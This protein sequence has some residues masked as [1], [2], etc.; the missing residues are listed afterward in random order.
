MEDLRRRRVDE[1]AVPLHVAVHPRVVGE[2]AQ[3]VLDDERRV[4]DL[5]H[6][7][8]GEYLYTRARDD[9]DP[10]ALT[11]Q[12]R[13]REAAVGEEAVDD[14]LER[15]NVGRVLDAVGEVAVEVAR[16]P[17]PE[18]RLQGGLDAA[19]GE[20]EVARLRGARCRRARDD[21]RGEL[22]GDRLGRRLLLHQRHRDLGVQHGDGGPVAL[23]A[24]PDGEAAGPPLRDEGGRLV[25]D[26]EVG[27]QLHRHV[28]ELEAEPEVVV[29]PARAQA[30]LA[31][32]VQHRLLDEVDEVLEA[33]PRADVRA[34]VARPAGDG[35]RRHAPALLTS[36]ARQPSALSPQTT[37]TLGSPAATRL[38]ASAVSRMP[39]AP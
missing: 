20:L 37:S 8:V 10:A 5:V 4:D 39:S 19:G 1:P 24:Q 35:D 12:A 6:V 11:E 13:D 34:L 38:T 17:R 18:E 30:A 27:R 21:Q 29:E 25:V 3:D 14:L 9:R 22:A 16:A 33:D 7:R 32:P 26:L 28:D 36:R 2:A 23:D 15:A 31:E